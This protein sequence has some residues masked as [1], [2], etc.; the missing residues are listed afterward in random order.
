MYVKAS[1]GAKFAN[2]KGSLR[3]INGPGS[4]SMFLSKSKAEGGRWDHYDYKPKAHLFLFLSV[5]IAAATAA[6]FQLDDIGGRAAE[7]ELEIVYL[8]TTRFVCPK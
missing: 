2:Q 4:Q 8:F 5:R 7:L 1:M 3:G 6:L